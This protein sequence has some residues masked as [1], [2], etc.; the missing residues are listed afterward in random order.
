M[1]IISKKDI[2]K[3]IRESK[4][5]SVFDIDWGCHGRLIIY[6]CLDI[7]NENPER[8]YKF[9]EEYVLQ[10]CLWGVCN[11]QQAVRTGDI[12]VFKFLLD[13]ENRIGT[14]DYRDNP[15]TLE[16]KLIPFILNVIERSECESDYE[17]ILAYA[18]KKYPKYMKKERKK[19]G[20]LESTAAKYNM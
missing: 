3:S 6:T 19:L 5:E 8:Y 12:K 2:L 20:Y 9:I 18:L 11:I 10:G 7:Y 13:N 15:N 16:K 17:E 4:A 1:N 14:S